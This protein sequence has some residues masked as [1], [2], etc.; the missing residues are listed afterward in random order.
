VHWPLSENNSIPLSRRSQTVTS[1]LTPL[2]PPEVNNYVYMPVSTWIS[3]VYDPAVTPDY[4]THTWDA[5]GRV[6]SRTI[7]SMA[8]M[9]TETTSFG[10]HDRLLNL[11][12]TKPAPT[13]VPCPLTTLNEGNNYSLKDSWTYRYG[14]GGIREQKRLM[15]S[16]QHDRLTCGV[17]PWVAYVLSPGRTAACCLSRTSSK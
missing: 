2:P 9:V 7:S 13:E 5:S 17:A 14:P 12:L 8:G 3:A 10:Y 4:I 11:V 16:P 1:W 6:A 15:T